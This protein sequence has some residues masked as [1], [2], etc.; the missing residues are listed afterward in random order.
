LAY[1]ATGNLLDTRNSIGLNIEAGTCIYV[2][3]TNNQLFTNLPEEILNDDFHHSSFLKG[4]PIACAGSI[5]V[6]NGKI[7]KV[8]SLSGHYKPGKQQLLAFL[9]YLKNQNVD[10]SN[11]L[12]KDHPNASEQ[13]ALYYLKHKGFLPGE[14]SYK[15][16][17]QYKNEKNKELYQWCLEKAI[18]LKHENAYFDKAVNL[19]NGHFYQKN[20]TEG[21]FILIDLKKNNSPIGDRSFDFLNKFYP[22]ILKINEVIDTKDKEEITKLLHQLSKCKDFQILDF[23]AEKLKNI[24]LPEYLAQTHDLILKLIRERIH[25]KKFIKPH[26]DSIIKHILSTNLT[27]ALPEY[28][29]LKSSHLELFQTPSPQKSRLLKKR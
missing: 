9:S 25:N 20:P 22:D 8:T 3:S 23:L 5:A 1:N 11:I 12:V 24:N 10:I 28:E 18:L 2:F 29:K 19:I 27:N 13:N 16:A 4:R 6:E 7:T 14:L 21:F 17:N 15:Q 26:E